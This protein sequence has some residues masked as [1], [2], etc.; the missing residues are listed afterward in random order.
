MSHGTTWVV[1]QS[2]ELEPSLSLLAVIVLAGVGT[3]VLFVASAFASWRRRE[4][5]YLLIT[6]AVG[7]L[8]V[9]SLV[10]FATV[11][12][13][14]PMDVHHFLEHTLDFLIAALVLYA[15][16]RSKPST[17]LDVRSTGE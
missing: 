7:A 13:R 16:Y 15:V 1:L 14:V 2:H 6:L 11:Y 17:G 3:G 5:R 8:F 12:G 4:L 10:G 9:R